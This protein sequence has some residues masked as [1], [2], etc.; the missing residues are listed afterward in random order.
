MIINLEF[1]SHFMCDE[2][3]QWWTMADRIPDEGSTVFCPNGH[4]NVVEGRQ[5]AIAYPE[6]VKVVP[7]VVEQWIEAVVGDAQN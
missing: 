6:G 5:S 7:F 1:L 2:C 3:G 4:P